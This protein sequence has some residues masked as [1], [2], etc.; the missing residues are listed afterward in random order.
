MTRRRHVLASV[1]GAVRLVAA[2][3]VLVRLAGAARRVPPLLPATDDERSV[4]GPA[5]APQIDVVVPARDEAPR[6][7][8]LLARV[9]GAPGVSE[10]I[11]V[12][13]G[14]TDTTAE[15]ARRARA[16]VVTG[17]ALP[18]GW[19]GKA[20]ALQ[21]GFEAS[22]ADWVVTLDADTRPDP[23]L[24]AAMVARATAD[25]LDVLTVAGRF[26]CPTAGL[27]WLHPAMLTTLV[28][29]YGPPGSACPT[30]PGRLL[31]NGQSTAV[32]RAAFLASGGMSPVA[33]HLVEDVALARHVV[34]AGGR[35]AFL[36]AS[37]LLSVRMY[38]T[39]ADTWRGWGR[40]LALPGVEPR[41]RQ[42]LDIATLAMTLVLPLPRLAIGRGDVLDVALVVTRA[43]TLAGTAR[44]YERRGVA[45]WC[46]PLADVIALAALARGLVTRRRTWRGR[47]YGGGR[48]GSPVRTAA[49]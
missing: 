33:G 32:R 1:T 12:D 21:Q 44:A 19:A 18:V 16:R 14:S 47:V 43:G 3:A 40:S 48:P 5:P 35:V 6:V 30:R 11:V 22:T 49:R 45:Y 15:L 37:S 10:V 4:G 13:D 17:S 8:P 42:L 2:A 27:R 9:V 36:D 24:P 34:R 29:R 31:A 46:S 26:E 41:W 25:G 7:P 39:F 28:Y 23:R 38:E 20:W